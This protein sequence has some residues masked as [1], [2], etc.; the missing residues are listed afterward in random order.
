M[1]S[2]YEWFEIGSSLTM[3]RILLTLA[4]LSLI[5]M[6]AALAVGLTI[7][8]LYHDP[9]FQTLH[10]AT[11][12]R[13]TG[14]AAAL[15][16]VL[17]ESVVVTYFVGT[18]RWCKEVTE[19]YRLDPEPARE[20]NRLK[21]RAF[22]WSTVGMLTIVGVIALGAASDPATGRQDTQSWANYH[23]AGALGGLLFVAWTYVTAWN[24]TS[25][26][27]TLIERIVAEVDR[28]RR[29]RGLAADRPP[30]AST[31]PPR[32]AQD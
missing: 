17:V 5:L 22:A 27:Q 11:V 20:S 30:P 29:D 16:V 6:A 31:A 8:D 3:T 19:T 2:P 28:I 18:S 13:L 1:S 4:S 21:R 15:M 23:L 7:G 25:A 32:A 12:H 14:I 10:W 26:N 24:L 9:S